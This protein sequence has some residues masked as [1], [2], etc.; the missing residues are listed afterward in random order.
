MKKRGISFL[1]A[2]IFLTAVSCS[3]ASKDRE[4]QLT[5]MQI[6]DRNG[7]QETISNKERLNKLSQSDFRLPQP[8]QKVV[9]VYAPLRKGEHSGK[10]QSIVTSYH[11][12]GQLWQ[13]LETVAG[14]AN[15]LYQEWH[16]NGNLRLTAQVIEGIGDVAQNS[17]ESWVFDGLSE[18]FDESGH[19][20]ATI[21]YDKGVLEGDS[22]YY[23]PTGQ[24]IR[25]IPFKNNQIDGEE[26]HFDLL[27]NKIGSFPYKN[28]L[29]SGHSYFV[30]TADRPRFEE[31]FEEGKLIQGTYYQSDGSIFSQVEKGRGFRS[32]F[33]EGFLVSQEQI[34]NG[35]LEGE[36]RFFDNYK[37][38]IHSYSVVQDQ[39][40]GEEIFFYPTGKVRLMVGWRG[41]EIHGLVRSWYENGQQESEREMSHNK[42][43]GMAYAWYKDGSLMLV[44]EYENDLLVNGK[45]M[46]R[47]DDYPVSKI[48]NGNGIAT[49]YDD[50]GAFL[51]RIEYRKGA[52]SEN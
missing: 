51:K 6:V 25:K 11:K 42:K 22:I 2:A 19:L 4:G 10:T 43:Q 38:L 48:K 15:G 7:F 35:V 23:A 47:G 49:L 18:A 37:N 31:D 26:E 52:P 29:R 9:R 17:K 27:E 1:L 36:M 24:I 41:D 33:E 8:Y 50:G 13:Y 40:E 16:E 30:G 3:S 20:I 5:S 28:G 21:Y 46:K 45:Y 39:K 44:E 14:R 34:Q 12:N 32:H